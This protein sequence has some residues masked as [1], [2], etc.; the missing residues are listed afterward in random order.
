MGLRSLS[1]QF[2]R[3]NT[4]RLIAPAPLSPGQEAPPF[5]VRADIYDG[6]PS[7]C[8]APPTAPSPRAPR[9]RLLGARGGGERERPSPLTL[10]ALGGGTAPLTFPQ[11]PPWGLASLPL[12]RPPNPV[13]RSPL[14]S[15]SHYLPCVDSLPCLGSPG[16][17]TE[18]CPQDP[19]TP[20]SLHSPRIARMGLHRPGPSLLPQSRVLLRDGKDASPGPGAY[21]IQTVHL[22]RGV[23]DLAAPGAVG[24]HG[25]GK[26][27]GGDAR[28]CARSLN[29]E[30]AGGRRPRLQLHRR[31]R[32]RLELGNWPPPPPSFP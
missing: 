20:P 16:F 10:P 11:P 4:R 28:A 30:R 5:A 17:Q 1:A 25:S 3:C 6:P 2:T 15:T 7:L 26:G 13:A 32:R 12:F 29:P 9:F 21:L 23:Y 31:W 19:M 18:D 24:I 8:P 14:F 22:L 27:W